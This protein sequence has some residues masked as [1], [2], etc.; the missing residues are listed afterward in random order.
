MPLPPEYLD[1]LTEMK[2]QY[3]RCTAIANHITEI[4]V[5]DPQLETENARIRAIDERL[6]NMRLELGF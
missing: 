5:V 6:K 2:A 4:G 3:E 1:L